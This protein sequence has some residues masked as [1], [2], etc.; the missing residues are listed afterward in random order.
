MDNVYFVRKIINIIFIIVSFTLISCEGGPSFKNLEYENLSIEYFPTDDVSDDH[1]NQVKKWYKVAADYWFKKDSKAF[2][3]F[4]PSYIAIIGTNAELARKAN[5]EFCEY[6]DHIINKCSWNN[7][8]NVFEEYA[9]NGSA[10]VTSIRAR[11][12]YH[13]IIM[14]SSKPSPGELHEYPYIIFH[15]TF[16]TYQKSYISL[17]D[18]EPSSENTDKL[19]G[20]YSGDHEGKVTWWAEGTANYLAQ[21]L[22]SRQPEAP[23]NWFKEKMRRW[24]EREKVNGLP[25]KEEYLNSNVDLHNWEFGNK[26]YVGRYVGDWFIAYLVNEFGEESIYEFYQVL[27]DSNFEDTFL[28]IYGKPYKVK[29][30]EFN[31]FFKQENDE[32]LKIIP[33]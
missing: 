31:E 25:V 14:S 6:D 13:L 27:P 4:S 15:E 24:L 7:N 22:Y 11:D 26:G 33:N 17:S 5:K 20:K 23:E 10:A 18:I 9:L 2:N 1:I 19:N 32:L 12:G 3:F 21:L 16:H 8:D 28:K 29:I 30:K